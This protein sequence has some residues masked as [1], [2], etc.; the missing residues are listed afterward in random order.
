MKPKHWLACGAA[1]AVVAGG[2][3]L[4]SGHSYDVQMVMPS[5]AQLSKRTPVWINGQ[6][7]GSITDLRVKDGK[8]VAT[9][10]ISDDFG[11][12][13]SGTSSRVEW[14]SAVGERV[15]T[16]YPGAKTNPV[17]PDGAMFEGPSR[18]IEVDQL[19]ATLDTKTRARLTSLLGELNQTV[20]GHEDDLRATIS[21]ASGTVNALGEVLKAVGSDGPAIRA[22][23]TELS[24]MT[25]VAGERRYKIAATVSNLSSVASSVAKEQSA[26]TGT[27][28]QLP[29]AMGTA[30]TTLGKVPRAA[31]ATVGLLKDLR[32]A[33]SKLPGVS[34]D[35]A[36]TLVDLRPAVAEL[37]PLLSAADQLLGETPE[38]LDTTHAVVPHTG[39][40][41]NGVEPAI[42]FLRPYTPEAV[43]GLFN[44]GQAFAPYDG[45]GH[46]WAGLLAPGV[47]AFNESPVPLPTTRENPEPAPGRAEGQ[48]WT[49]ATGS[50]IR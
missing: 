14:V 32:P 23:V 41:F 37:R 38:L 40:L 24:Q 36:P 20:G 26:L 13:H 8:A 21:T 25:N 9:L 34:A 44:W 17:I 16:V 6:H 2:A 27:L 7:A 15:L 43:G 42:S 49:D 48:P 35:L 19:L 18:Q 11:P 30:Q 22:L 39:D 31:D 29:G 28:N 10:S 12:L 47:N 4:M 46:T 1:I 5:A 33:T 50:G 45:A 3:H